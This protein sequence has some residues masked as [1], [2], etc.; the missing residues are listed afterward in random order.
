MDHQFRPLYKS[1]PRLCNLTEIWLVPQ[2][3]IRQPVNSIGFWIYLSM[4][5]NVCLKLLP[6]NAS[7]DH[8]DTAYFYDSVTSSPVKPCGLCIKHHF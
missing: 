5:I 2:K 3:F 6:R 4:R 1:E 8:L 7:I